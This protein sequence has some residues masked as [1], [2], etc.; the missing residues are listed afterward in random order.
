MFGKPA[1]GSQRR[2]KM[3]LVPDQRNIGGRSQIT[4]Q[5][6]NHYNALFNAK[7]TIRLPDSRT[8]E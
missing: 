6:F 8:L 1:S 2:K 5:M 4:Q 7:P 3:P